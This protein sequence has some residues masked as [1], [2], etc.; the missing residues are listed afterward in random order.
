MRYLTVEQV[1]AIRFRE[2]IGKA[3]LTDFPNEIRSMWV[4]EYPWRDIADELDLRRRFPAKDNTL[5]GA[6]SYAVKELFGDKSER[7]EL[8]RL[9]LQNRG[10]ECYR[11]RQG[12]HGLTKEELIEASG[13]GMVSQGK[14]N[15]SDSETK[16]L[17][18]IVN[19]EDYKLSPNRRSW[20]KIVGKLNEDYHVGE[21]VRTIKATRQHYWLETKLEDEQN[22]R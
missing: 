7:L 19:H 13:R 15:W 2:K 21:P 12:V 8:C 11:K 6:I 1:A 9:H 17:M 18:D 14:T 20:N 22:E 5:K 4:N 16:T 10:T 3:L